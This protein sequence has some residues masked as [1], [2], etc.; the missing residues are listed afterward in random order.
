MFS[1]ARACLTLGIFANRLPNL[2]GVAIKRQTT[3]VRAQIARANT[4]CPT[5]SSPATQEDLFGSTFNGSS[6]FCGEARRDA[7]QRLKLSTI[8]PLGLDLGET[9][10]G[11][12]PNFREVGYRSLQ[13]SVG[14]ILYRHHVVAFADSTLS[15]QLSCAFRFLRRP[16]RPNPAM[17]VAKSP[18]APGSGPA[19]AGGNA[20][21]IRPAPMV[22]NR[23]APK[24]RNKSFM[25]GTAFN[26][27]ALQSRMDK[28][29]K[30]EMAGQDKGL[31][32]QRP[33]IE[34]LLAL[35]WDHREF[36]PGNY[37]R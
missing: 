17:P 15:N 26:L 21:T 24:D 5:T 4:P 18:R 11:E 34:D 29:R 1:C 13:Q 20:N 3:G 23:T 31:L 30:L 27:V 14:A 37:R 32:L 19:C 25:R 9:V 36:G 7:G 33:K 10:E 12:L 6:P 16:S 22:N 8:G 28:S 2:F 35:P